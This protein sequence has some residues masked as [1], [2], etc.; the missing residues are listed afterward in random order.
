MWGET[1]GGKTP[2]R[3]VYAQLDTIWRELVLCD[4]LQLSSRD[5]VH[6]RLSPGVQHAFR[7]AT[8][9]DCVRLEYVREPECAVL[10]NEAG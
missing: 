8:L 1:E 3:K 5:K 10:F 6:V 7:L 4:T 9:F 2:I